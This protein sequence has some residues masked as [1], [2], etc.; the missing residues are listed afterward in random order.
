MVL[1]ALGAL[2]VARVLIT[3]LPFR[4]IVRLLGDQS[5]KL[6][7][8]VPIELTE[9]ATTQIELIAWSITAVSRHVPWNSMCYPKCLA[10]AWMLRRRKMPYKIYF[11]LKKDSSN[12]VAALLAHS[13]VE[14]GDRSL[15]GNQRD[16]GFAKLICISH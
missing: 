13:W 11:G 6:G 4:V 7:V 10:A 1:E 8:A 16:L 2:T 3:V 15:F 5:N 14:I 9:E 12:L